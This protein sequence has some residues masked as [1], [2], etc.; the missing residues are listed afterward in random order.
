MVQFLVDSTISTKRLQWNSSEMELAS[1]AVNKTLARCLQ[2][3]F[4]YFAQVVQVTILKVYSLSPDETLPEGQL[5]VQSLFTS[6]SQYQINMFIDQTSEPGAAT[7]S[8]C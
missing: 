1:G 5:H 6:F 4:F 7:S 3:F 8:S 2:L